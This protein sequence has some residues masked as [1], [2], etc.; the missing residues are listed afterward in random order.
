MKTMYE[1][2]FI[3]IINVIQKSDTTQIFC[4]DIAIPSIEKIGKYFV[5]KL[6]L[7]M[8]KQIFCLK[9]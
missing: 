5:K 1:N 4:S 7:I 2:S 3:H 8:K 6:V 9:N